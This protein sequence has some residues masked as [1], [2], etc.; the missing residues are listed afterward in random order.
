MPAIQF[1]EDGKKGMW[2][3]IL[4]EEFQKQIGEEL[5]EKIQTIEVKTYTDDSTLTSYTS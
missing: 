4:S 2:L 5:G 1:I 3:D